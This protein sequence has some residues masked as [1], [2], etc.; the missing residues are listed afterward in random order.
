LGIIFAFFG[1][2]VM[3]QFLPTPPMP[4]GELKDFM[5]VMSTTHYLWV[6]GFFQFVPGILLL[7][8]R[9]VPLA[10]T[11]LAAMIVNILTTHI[12]VMHG[13]GLIPFPVLVVILWL[14]VFWNVRSAF[15][16]IFQARPAD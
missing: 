14:I 15:A 6:V 7:I 4:P 3:F 8:N 10:L 5:T 13:G 2:N 12:F 1:S 16:G 11:V 9:Y